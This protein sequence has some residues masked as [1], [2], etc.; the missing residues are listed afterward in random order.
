MW[1]C[2]SE[3]RHINHI[4]ISSNKKQSPFHSAK[5]P[6]FQGCTAPCRPELGQRSWLPQRWCVTFLKS[7]LLGIISPVNK[8]DSPSHSSSFS[9]EKQPI[10]IKD[11]LSSPINSLLRAVQSIPAGFAAGRLHQTSHVGRCS[12]TGSKSI[13]L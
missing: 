9:R 11:D 6:R 8:P 2:F 1:D 12:T 13:C 4:Y 10:V 7:S 3:T 5:K